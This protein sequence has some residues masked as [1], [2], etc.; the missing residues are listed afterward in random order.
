LKSEHV[1]ESH[2]LAVAPYYESLGPVPPGRGTSPCWIPPSVSVN[3][4]PHIIQFVAENHA[5]RSRIETSLN[6]LSPGCTITWTDS[7]TTN[8]GT[9]IIS[10]GG[11]HTGISSI[12]TLNACR[13]GLCELLGVIKAGSIDV[14]QDIWPSFVEQWEEQFPKDDKSVCIQVDP[15]KCCVHVVGEQEK[16]EEMRARLDGL[17]SDLVEKFRRSKTR[18]TEHIPNILLHQISLLDTCGFF[19][20]ESADDFTAGVV[21]DVIMLEG[22]PDKVIDWKVK[23]YKKLAFAQSETARVDEYVLTVLKQEPFHRHLEQLLQPITGVVWY[24]AGEAIEVYGED[25]DKVSRPVLVG[26]SLMQKILA[27][28]I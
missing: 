6:D 16:Y 15:D 3:C 26:E 12:S 21:D 23:M 19:K 27:C 4:D 9:V 22:Q 1:L 24:T 20:T 11:V 2:H 10:F 18:I 5:I 28:E 13:D 25:Q 8:N 7:T 17:R 14:L